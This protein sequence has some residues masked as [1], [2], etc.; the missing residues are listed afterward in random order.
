MDLSVVIPVKDE[1]DN[2]KALLSRLG[3]AVR[4]DKIARLAGAEGKLRAVVFSNGEELPRQALFFNTGQYQRSK[5]PGMLGC[6]I[7]EKDSVVTNPKCM[8]SKPGVYLAGDASRDVQ[9]AIVAA[10]EGATAAFAINSA[11]LE[12]D[13]GEVS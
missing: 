9:L 1:K 6:E 3:I 8:T 5:L 11:L 4:M 13:F 7:N 2:L 12:E 10:A